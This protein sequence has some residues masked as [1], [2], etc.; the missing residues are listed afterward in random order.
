[1]AAAKK[2]RANKQRDLQANYAKLLASRAKETKAKQTADKEKRRTS[3]TRS[4]TSE[5]E[6]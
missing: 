4:R 1:M 5:S 2:G 3:S 6:K